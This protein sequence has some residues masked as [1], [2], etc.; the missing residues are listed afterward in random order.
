MK[1]KNIYRNL[2]NLGTKTKTP[3][4][5]YDDIL[6][7][8][9]NPHPDC[10]YVTRFKT[11]EFTSL[12]PVTGQP[13]FAEIIIDYIPN[14][15]IIESKSLKLFFQSF[16]NHNDF[17]EACTIFIAKKIIEKSNPKWLRIKAYWTPRG[18]IPIH[19]F[20]QTSIPP[21]DVFIDNSNQ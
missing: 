12:C 15:K 17:H 16:R 9:E 7:T 11:N 8:V 2:K 21:K 14:K 5:P 13:D 18:G 10:N 4:S 3:S 1:N 20:Y 19:I 6:E